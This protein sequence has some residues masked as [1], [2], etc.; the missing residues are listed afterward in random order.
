M[1]RRWLLS[2][3][4]LSFVVVFVQLSSANSSLRVNESATKFLVRDNATVQLEVVNPAGHKVSAHLNLELLDPKDVVRGLTIRDVELQPGLNKLTLPLTL[5]A[6]RINEEDDSELPWYRLRYRFDPSAE[7]KASLGPATGIISLSEIDLP[8]IFALEVSAPDRTQ[9]SARYQAHIR[10]LH[11]ITAKPVKNVDVSME[12]RFSEEKG[13]TIKGSGLTD[14]DGY[15]LVVVEIPAKL[16][17]DEAEMK[18]VARRGGFVRKVGHEV[19]LKDSARIMV[20]TDKPIYQPGQPL[21][22]RA[23]VFDAGN[24]AVPNA[25]ATLTITDP[26]DTEVF[27]SS[28]ITSRFGVA[29]ADWSIPENTRLGDYSIRI[30]MDDESYGDADGFQGVKISRYDL[31]NFA[32]NMKSNRSYYLPGQNADVEI[33]AD[34]LFGQPVK[35]GRVK[36]VQEEEREWD[37]KKQ[38]WEIKEGQKHEG[39]TDETGLFIAHIDLAKEH[40]DLADSDYSRFTDLSFAAYFT[41]PTTNRTEQ[42]RFDLRVTKDSIHIYVVEGP[43]QQSPG[44]PMQFYLATSFADGAPAPCEVA[45]SEPPAKDSESGISPPVLR[46]IRTNKY[47]LAKVAGLV[48]PDLARDGYP[49]LR[50]TAMSQGSVA[51]H[52]TESFYYRDLPVIRV[53]TNKA[54]YAPGEA[55]QVNINASKPDMSVVVEVAR[56]SDIIE[57]KSLALQNGAASLTLRSRPAFKDEITI[58]VFSKSREYP[59]SYSFPFGSRT[60]LFPRNRDLK[61]DFR[62]DHTDY[63]PGDNATVD[64]SISTPEGRPVNSALGVVIFDRAVEER[65]R[66]DQ[67]FRGQF[68][69]FG[70]FSQWRGYDNQIAGITRRTLQNIDAAK[71][72]PEEMALAAELLLGSGSERSSEFTSEGFETDYRGVFANLTRQQLEP[73]GKLLDARYNQGGFYPASG[74]SL[75]RLLVESG[76][77]FDQFYD[78]WGTPYQE[79]FSVE[80]DNLIFEI[81]SAGPDKSF[82]TPDDSSLTRIARPYFRYTGEAINRAVERFHARTGGFIRSLETL[83]TELRLEGIDLD[84]LRDNWGQPYEFAFTTARDKF[85]VSV[86]SSGPDKSFQSADAKSDDFALWQTSINYFTE[87]R[88][89]IDKALARSFLATNAFPKDDNE[90]HR[91]LLD[92]GLRPDQLRDPWGNRFTGIYKTE[93]RVSSRPVLQSLAV[94]GQT[95]NGTIGITPVK[96]VIGSVRLRSIGEDGKA[97]TDDDFDVGEFS[98]SRPSDNERGL[99]SIAPVKHFLPSGGRGAIRGTVVDSNAG[100]VTGAVVTAT[101]KTSSLTFETRTD[102]E[103]KFLLENLPVGLYEVKCDASGFMKAI[104]DGVPVS[105]ANITTVNV[106]INPGTVSET[107][108]ITAA[109]DVV[110]LTS[111]TTA[112]IVTKSGLQVSIAHPPQLATPRLREYFPETLVWQ[113]SLETDKQGRAQLKFKLADNITTWKMSVI[114]ST[115]DGE[116]GTAETEIKSFQPFF[117]EHDPPRVLTE[118]DQIS[119]PVVLRNYL[120][121]PQVVDLEMKPASWFTLQ[122]APRQRATVPAGDSAKQI[123]EMKAVAS[124]KDGKQQ[125]TARGSEAGDAIEKPVTVH[126]D[127]EEKTQTASNVFGDTAGLDI[128]LPASV[129]RGSAR[130]ELKIYPSLMAHVVESIEGILERPYGCGEQTISSTYPSVLILRGNQQTKIDARIVAKAKSYA[131]QGYQ[132]L[133]KY[134]TADGGFAYWESDDADLALSAYALRFLR[135]A[136]QFVEVDPEV[137]K[138]LRQW[139]IKRQQTD[140]SF[141]ATGYRADQPGDPADALLSAYVTRVLAM[142]ESPVKVSG[143]L[144]ARPSPGKASPELQHALSYLA[145]KIQTVDEPHLIASYALAA[146]DAGDRAGAQRAIAKL[147]T[148]A[149]TEDDTTYWNL[150]TTTPFNGWG[151]AGRVETTALVIQALTHFSKTA[152][153]RPDQADSLT[154]RGLLFLLRQKDRYG[155]WYSTQATI[156][157]LDTLMSLLAT[158]SQAG[159]AAPGQ[160]V[161]IDVIVN[162]QPATSLKSPAG[163][164]NTVMIRA[165][166]SAFLRSGTNRVELRR[167]RGS[168]IASIQ[169]V[170]NYYVPWST[171]DYQTKTRAPGSVFLSAK[172][173]KHV[174]AINEEIV[175]SVKAQRGSTVTGM[176]LAEIGLPPGADVD[177]AS[178]ES[179]MKNSGWA[180]SRYDVL[181]DRVVF[182][183]WADSGN[184]QF[185]FKFRPR[186]ALTAKAAPSTIYDYYNPEAGAVVEPVTFTVR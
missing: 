57:S 152:S 179:A 113:P 24:R 1:S 171:Q 140:G 27:E 51:G 79:K 52:H 128:N 143:E 71:P 64:F 173:D 44:L 122:G 68:G 63:K 124:V 174:G 39:E 11:P 186:F 155:V 139:L 167:P 17:S 158:D 69:F 37:F 123:F 13:E 59:E 185:S 10:T 80:R 133:L 9:R 25:E 22:V 90:F 180:M 135:D 20:N 153:T 168:A 144:N 104:V 142:T 183:F 36:V 163:A 86:Y 148:L 7:F 5:P 56:G 151:N 46:N 28:L 30:E 91:T 89:Q 95:G 23:L 18:V 29:T 16:S 45:I 99:V 177:R 114:G 134:R 165:D 83:R 14:A 107:V 154:Q 178:L 159:V 101:H 76:L 73:I 66:T 8:D 34:Y 145:A 126:P 116:M 85:N 149:Q 97:G 146:T 15:A 94:Y 42:R 61:V 120:E 75:R 78:P 82:A 108:N 119:L 182:Y 33:R 84:S 172:F 100:A 109:G 77:D 43:N 12:L 161:M 112:T 2:L 72:L 162:G 74:E 35:R 160:P 6:A 19:E 38:S 117:L 54:L 164:Q 62:L 169:L 31:P 121:R 131:A 110:N 176:M 55:I 147:R 181:P 3:L 115:E 170:A 111:S 132:R 67:E 53:E 96:E 138:S 175:C 65:A 40:K 118:G 150:D 136:S 137:I 58:S 130:A 47:G 4:C 41:D 60:V 48:L 156:N 184:A 127:G 98:R 106:S 102:D 70:S 93:T 81:I 166:V 50:F 21:H 88:V 103:G 92:S 26:E 32:V 157:V 105:S 141:S 125:I 87:T 129:I 49:S